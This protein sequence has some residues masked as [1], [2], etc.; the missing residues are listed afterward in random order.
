[1]R[2]Q[3]CYHHPGTLQEETEI[4][5]LRSVVVV[6]EHLGVTTTLLPGPE[7]KVRFLKEN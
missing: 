7:Q 5:L 6:Q 1:M 3:S 2:E 4:V